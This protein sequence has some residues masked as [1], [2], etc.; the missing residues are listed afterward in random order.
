MTQIEGPSQLSFEPLNRFDKFRGEVDSRVEGVPQS[1]V[2]VDSYGKELSVVA[3]AEYGGSTFSN[4][5]FEGMVD[6]LSLNSEKNSIKN[7]PLA[8]YIF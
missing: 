2:G 5:R 4:F 7:F 1:F 6:G 8:V 3:E